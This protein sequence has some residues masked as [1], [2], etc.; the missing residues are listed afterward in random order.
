MVIGTNGKVGIGG[1]LGNGKVGVKVGI[2]GS[3]RNIDSWKDIGNGGSSGLETAGK[4]V[5]SS[6][7]IVNGSFLS[8]RRPDAQHRWPRKST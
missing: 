1:N 3:G 7:S 6:I 2:I 5:G 4:K 8:S